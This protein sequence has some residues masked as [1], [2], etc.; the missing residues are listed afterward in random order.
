MKKA[1]AY[2]IKVLRRRVLAIQR[3][4]RAPNLVTRFPRLGNVRP[5]NNFKK[6]IL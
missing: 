6:K 4:I 2:I 1:I 5:I 3:Q